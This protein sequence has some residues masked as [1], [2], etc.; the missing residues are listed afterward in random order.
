LYAQSYHPAPRT[1]G[2]QARREIVAGE[3]V[4]VNDSS[5][6]DG[7]WVMGHLQSDDG[8]TRIR[9]VGSDL[10]GVEVGRTVR[11]TGRWE[12]HPE[13]GRQFRAFEVESE[14]PVVREA[15]V[16]FLS[17][18]VKH[19]GEKTAG[20]IVDT[21]G[22]GALEILIRQPERVRDAVP[23]KKGDR[24]LAS[25]RERV[26]DWEASKGA[27]ALSVRLMGAGMTY[28]MARKVQQ[29][30]KKRG[31]TEEVVLLHPYRLIEVP[32]IGFRTA[33]RIAQSM[34]VAATD[35]SRIASGVVFALETAMEMGHS[36][37]PRAEL[38]KLAA[39]ELGV[40][41]GALVVEAVDR[42][43]SAGTLVEDAELIYVPQ[44]LR[45]ERFVA[46]R[47]A[48]LLRFRRHL[49]PHQAREVERILSES[50][51]SETQGQAV[52][53]ALLGGVFVLTGR[54]GSG[55]TTTTRTFVRC[56][57]A[58]GLTVS[59]AAPTGKAA[60]R[61]SEVT[62]LQASTVHRMIG[63]YPGEI[64]K[65]PLEADVIVVD[66]VSMMDLEVSAWLLRNLDPAR[67][68]IVYVGDRAQLPSVGHGS[69]LH[70]LIESEVVPSVELTEIF[71]QAAGS[72]I[73]TNAHRLLD[74]KPLL[75]DNAP[76]ADFLFAD[77]TDQSAVDPQT[78]FPL[79]AG[80]D[81]ERSAREQE[82]ARGRLE[83]ALHYLIAQK[84]ASPAR[85]IQVMTPMRRGS[86]GVDSLNELLQ[87]TLNPHGAEGPEIGG[88]VR[89]RTGDR[90]IQTR[91]DYLVP[92]GLFNGEQGEVVRS[93][94]RNDQV[95][96]RFEDREV[97]LSG[98]QLGNLR[99]AWAITVHRSQGSE[100]PYT[101]MVYHTAHYV[102][103]SKSLLYTAITRARKMFVLI[104]N[105]AAVEATLKRGDDRAH[106]HT[107]LAQR[108]TAASLR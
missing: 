74:G 48:E 59:L 21:F 41:A 84:G 1:E 91:N 94:P 98:Y 76:D 56:C 73:I 13:H 14:L 30:F 95:V 8:S 108:V 44:A 20:A 33:D 26:E 46:T 24:V 9:F 92:G 38:E 32:G 99:L 43:L 78:G 19:C 49:A 103:L 67:T 64:R 70:D 36:A 104:G 60:A 77:V 63:G 27:H 39:K 2:A 85:D 107:G 18:N 58:L 86:L 25:L 89:V 6:S 82:A 15:I 80:A 61:A 54:P 29:Y 75:L 42:G 68:S 35:P 37:M 81:P 31:E 17:C 10:V 12:S 4:T 62:G 28:K 23:G 90:V 3:V 65:E 79:P 51:L 5:K 16:R 66:E 40:T 50:G 34:G 22:N 87:R 72:R 11:L 71:R 97:T 52:W 45:D 47:I 69:F 7:S 88:G 100:F 93:A 53:G 57:H 105:Y 55:K 83:R 96:V 101:L 106:R 102:M